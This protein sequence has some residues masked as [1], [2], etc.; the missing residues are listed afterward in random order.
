MPVVGGFK[1]ALV[2]DETGLNGDN[3]IPSGCP[4]WVIW[5]TYA[6]QTGTDV[7]QVTGPPCNAKRYVRFTPESAQLHCTSPCPLWAIADILR[8]GNARP[9]C[10]P[11][12]WIWQFHER[13]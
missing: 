2:S 10:D 4:L 6:A 11:S 1:H 5:R 12:R 3:S 9:T 8:C 7:F 13:D